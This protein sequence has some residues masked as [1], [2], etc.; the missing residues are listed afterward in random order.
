MPKILLICGK[1]CSGKTTYTK[2]LIKKIK[3]VH[4]SADEISLAIFGGHIGEAHAEVVGKIISYI[5][6]KSIEL[7]NTGFN[8]VIDT[9]FWQKADRDEANTFY[10]KHSIIP[11][12]HY[13]DV[14]DDL[15]R[16]N[17]LKRN[18]DIE[19]NEAVDYTID[20]NTM[21][22]FLRFWET[23]TKDEI[24]VWHILKKG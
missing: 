15:W 11:E 20:D 6:D 21:N 22:F 14:S 12:W 4:L 19:N 24:D 8:V 3:A 1:I 17:I 7:Y 13:I 5:F 10:K 16:Q 2:K 23:P 9:G 18:Q